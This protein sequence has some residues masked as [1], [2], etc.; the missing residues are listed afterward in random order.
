MWDFAFRIS[1][2]GIL[3]SE[4]LNPLQNFGVRVSGFGLRDSGSGLRDSGIW[5]PE[6]WGSDVGLLA[7]G[8][9]FWV[10]NYGFRFSVFGFRVYL[11]RNFT[12]T[13]RL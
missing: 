8:L 2:F 6:F 13:R 3:E 11:V 9:G 1:G 5:L 12:P 7:W 4:I 10:S